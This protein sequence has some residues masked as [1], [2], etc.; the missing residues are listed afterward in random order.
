MVAVDV[1]L[2][3]PEERDLE[4]AGREHFGDRR[5]GFSH[6]GAE[7]GLLALDAGLRDHDHLGLLVNLHADAALLGVIEDGTAVAVRLLPYLGEVLLDF[8]GVLAAVELGVLGKEG[9]S[10]PELMQAARIGE[11]VCDPDILPD[12]PAGREGN[13]LGF[14]E[15]REILAS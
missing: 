3:N 1:L 12:G 11:E 13:G 15:P 2:L 8:G 6:S 14:P 4:I 5:A 10:Q 7:H 9:R